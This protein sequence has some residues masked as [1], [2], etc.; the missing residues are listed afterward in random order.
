LEGLEVS[1]SGFAAD[2]SVIL[3][4]LFRLASFSDATINGAAVVEA[5][6]TEQNGKWA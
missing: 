5:Y 6:N 2:F 4:L 1:Q 3:S